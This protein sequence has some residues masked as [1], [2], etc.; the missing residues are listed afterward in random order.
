MIGK[1]S[2]QLKF[3]LAMEPENEDA[4]PGVITEEEARRREF[5]ARTLFEGEETKPAWF[6][7]Y[8]EL[9]RGGWPFRVAMYI[10]WSASPR[11]T[12]SPRTLDELANLMG[13]TSPRA[14]HIWRARNPAINEQVTLMQAAPLMKH[15]ADVIHALVEMASQPDYKSHNDRKLFFE[16]TGDYVR[17]GVMKTE[18]ASAADMSGLSEDELMDWLAGGEDPGKGADEPA[19]PTEPAPDPDGGEA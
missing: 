12:R 9:I 10:A 16:M 7:E 4:P 8:E 11:T 5:Q 14:I 18:R 13:L 19:E 15:R 6:E 17:R 1:I 3:E 2:Y